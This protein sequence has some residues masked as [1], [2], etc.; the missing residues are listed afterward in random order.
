M[1]NEE[2]KIEFEVRTRTGYIDGKS[3]L[4]KV[5]DKV[6]KIS[7]SKIIHKITKY[8]ETR[9]LNSNKMKKDLK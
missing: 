4:K 1:S 5:S 6:E 8:M 2:N 3:R 9:Y 7:I